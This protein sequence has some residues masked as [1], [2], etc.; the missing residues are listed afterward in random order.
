MSDSPAG[1]TPALI[2]LNERG[3]PFEEMSY[4]HS[5]HF[6]GGYGTEAATQLGASRDEV[7]KTL[8]LEVDGEAVAAL[9]PASRR[10][11][12]KK[13]ARAVGGK[14]A[15]F[16]EPGKA[17]Q[18]SGYVVGG[19]SPFGQK[20]PHRILLDEGALELTGIIVSGG[21]R[22]LSIRMRVTDFLDTT[23]ALVADICAQ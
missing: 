1:A 20:H 12:Q 19:I 13:V 17:Q 22:G 9:V 8:M 18:R 3:V 15:E 10:L 11:S 7:F 4:R 5:D 14:R 6:S 21:R 23:E 16:M 2:Y